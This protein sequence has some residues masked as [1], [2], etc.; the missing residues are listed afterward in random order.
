MAQLCSI[1]RLQVD[2]LDAALAPDHDGEEF[3][4]EIAGRPAIRVDRGS[5]ERPPDWAAALV[6]MTGEP[7][8]H[9]TRSAGSV[10]LV[11]LGDV[12]Y[13][14]AFGTG[15]H[16]LQ[17]GA[18]V[19]DFGI[20]V[21]IR[22]LDPDRV[23][24]VTRTALDLTNRHDLTQLPAGGHVRAFGI[25]QYSEIVKEI[26]GRS[27]TLDITHLRN[28][29]GGV[30]LEGR[31]ALRLRVAASPDELV[32]D[33]IAI[34]KTYEQ[35]PHPDLAFIEGLRPI[36]PKDVRYARAR[37]ALAQEL[38]KTTSDRVGL[39]IPIGID[40]IAI[41]TFTVDVRGT[42]LTSEEPDFDPIRRILA[43]LPVADRMD[44]LDS[45]RVTLSVAG[46]ADPV[47]TAL[48]SWIAADLTV[49]GEQ[50]VLHEGDLFVMTDRY[51]Q[52]LD[53]AVDDLLASGSGTTLPVWTKGIVEGDYCRQVGKRARY[54]LLDQRL[55]RGGA[56]P[57]GIE[58]CDLLGPKGELICI[59]RAE[60]S[61]TL[62]HLFFQAIVAAEDLTDGD[63]AYQKLLDMLPATR[64]KDVARRP[65]FVFAIQL[66]SGKALSVA[67]MFTFAKVGL[68]RAARHL[69]RL[70]MTV[71]VISIPAR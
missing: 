42:V 54:V 41:G 12:S 62:S 33:L 40:S 16:F 30:K 6:G 49:S 69:H 48:S 22:C 23:A 32:A 1:Y 18:Y 3:R 14:L 7:F 46:S 44:A 4:L 11:S 31:H 66:A 5:E 19:R 65:H 43:G 63:Q 38:G 37:H 45:G 51:R 21:A 57:K 70:N 20:A 29:R 17:E 47:G 60:K 53:T 13:A 8:E 56:H 67:S 2:R 71:S 52:A 27:N 64:R 61:S 24:E 25:E 36:G 58:I 68:F 55:V 59:K 15:W 26:G 39:A 10:V 50:F 28:S 9:M 35:D 34:E